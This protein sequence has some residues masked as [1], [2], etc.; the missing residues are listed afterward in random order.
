M[1]VRVARLIDRP[2]I[3]PDLHVDPIGRQIVMSFHRLAET[4]RNKS[5][6]AQNVQCPM[7]AIRQSGSWMTSAD[8]EQRCLGCGGC[9]TRG[10]MVAVDRRGAGIRKGVRL[11]DR[12][13]VGERERFADLLDRDADRRA[14]RDRRRLRVLIE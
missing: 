6:L 4:G 5:G 8:P 14:F 13:R 9:L 12:R 1:C 2:I 10:R 11:N 7:A 3:S